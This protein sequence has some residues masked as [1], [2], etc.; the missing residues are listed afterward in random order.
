MKIQ[1]YSISLNDNNYL[2][3]LFDK[4]MKTIRLRIDNNVIIVSGYHLSIDKAN[5]FIYRHQ[6]WI[7]KK[8]TIANK[9][10]SNLRID[11]YNNFKI[12][13]L[14]GEIIDIKMNDDYY[15]I[16]NDS[17]KKPKK[18]NILTEQKKLRDY[19]LDYVIR[20]YEYYKNIFGYSNSIIYKDMKSRYGYCNINRNLICLSKRLIHLPTHLIDYVI[21]HE[22]C[23]FKY[24]N[25]QREFYLEVSKYYPS[26][27]E[28]KKELKKYNLLMK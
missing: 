7:I 24:P 1:T 19:Y 3:K 12:F 22:F 2:V 25:H 11:D 10:S 14:L 28:A 9:S 15:Q 27:K 5:E 18:F 16:G 8:I 23:H 13:Y 6:D 20:R 4:K 26:F 21:V 17:F